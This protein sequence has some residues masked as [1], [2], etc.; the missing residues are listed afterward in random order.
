MAE[1]VVRVLLDKRL[2]NGNVLTNVFGLWI[3]SILKVCS[4]IFPAEVKFVDLRLEDLL[5]QGRELFHHIEVIVASPVLMYDASTDPS[6][7]AIEIAK[8]WG[9]LKSYNN[10]Q[11]ARNFTLKEATNINQLIFLGHEETAQNCSDMFVLYL[12]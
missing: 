6:L 12:Y 9:C 8:R 5:Y 3:R 1:E 7:L 2:G 4:S 11:K 10:A